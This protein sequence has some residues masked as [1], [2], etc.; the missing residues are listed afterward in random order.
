MLDAIMPDLKVDADG[1][2]TWKGA[3]MGTDEGKVTSDLKGCSVG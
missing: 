3:P 2:V 1:V